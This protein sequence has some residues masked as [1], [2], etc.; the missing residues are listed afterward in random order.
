MPRHQTAA[1]A[2]LAALLLAG[3]A[4]AQPGKAP[5]GDRDRDGLTDRQERLLG[6]DPERADTDGDGTKDGREGGGRVVARRGDRLVVAMFGG[7]AVR[8]KLSGATDVV[9]P[10]LEEDEEVEEEVPLEAEDVAEETEAPVDAPAE[11]QS[12]PGDE[13]ADEEPVEDEEDEEVLCDA[14]D[15]RVGTVVAETDVAGKG[16]R[17]RWTRIELAP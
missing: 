17:R 10:E 3:P 1:L 15:L 11:L 2:A 16:K 14:D 7:G 6:T 9:C 8:A 13:P 5:R 12:T 4:V